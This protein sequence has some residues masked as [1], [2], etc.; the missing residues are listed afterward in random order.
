MDQENC[1][2]QLAVP[3]HSRAQTTFS[4]AGLGS[5]LIATLF[6]APSHIFKW[7]KNEPDSSI[8]DFAQRFNYD[9]FVVCTYT[10]KLRGLN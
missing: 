10:H 4:N 5:F 8:R 1:E 2:A 6:S 3:E 7:S 9:V